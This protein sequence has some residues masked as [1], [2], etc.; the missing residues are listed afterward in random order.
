MRFML[1]MKGR[2]FN[3]NQSDYQHYGGRGITM[4]E[5]WRNNARSFISWALSKGY[6]KGLE[7]DRINNDGNY[8][9]SNCRI[10]THTVN[11]RNTRSNVL[12]EYR[13]ETKTLSHW[14][15]QLN[16]KYA[17]VYSRL[18]Q[19]GYDVTKSFEHPIRSHSK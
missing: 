17:S 4:C 9:P 8:E 13:G 11:V 7:I 2:C 3:K 19:L 6:Q 5:E 16:L 12:I 10:V 15:E 18:Y 14:C 1:K